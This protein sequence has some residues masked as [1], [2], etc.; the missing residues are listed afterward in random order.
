MSD[1]TLKTRFA[2]S[3]TGE[4]HLGNVRTALF[5]ALLARGG[6]GVF[7]L[8]IE[9]TDAERSREAYTDSLL[10]DLRWL[11]LDWDEG[12][13]FQRQRSD[14]YR[15]YYDELERRGASYPCFCSANELARTRRAQVAAGQPPRYAGTC[16]QLSA[17]E[18]RNRL[19]AG[20]RPAIRFRVPHG[21][22][23]AFHDLARGE[24]AFLSD[25]IGDFIIRRSDGSA[26]FLFTNA[27]DD[28]VMRVTHVLRGEDHLANTPRQ[29]M[30]L[31]A[32][33]LQPPAYGH[34][35]LLLAGDGVPLSKR[36]GSR[37]VR[38]LRERGYLPG[39]LLN[40]LARLGHS[41]D[42][43]AYADFEQLAAGFSLQRLGRAPAR[44]DGEQLR[45][46]QRQAL[47]AATVEQLVDWFKWSA[48]GAQLAPQVDDSALHAL[49]AMV[50]ENVT[51]PADLA[52][53]VRRLT[54]DSDEFDAD[55]RSVLRAAG[56]DFFQ[57][58]LDV[59]PATDSFRD[60]ANA[61]GR[62]TGRKGRALFLPLRVA[63]TG[64]PHGP[65]M[66]QIWVWLGPERCRERLRRALL[67]CSSGETPDA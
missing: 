30:L 22:R 20:A 47:N 58:A 61:T 67:C 55:S 60:F 18:V 56:S 26:A 54:G 12:P 14:V 35:A 64:A 10:T 44:Y 31:R 66:Q 27:I 40:Y 43:D 28:A 42:S 24:Q 3:P 7:L 25:D 49:V 11:G 36:H 29:V 13:Y 17:T 34:L 65:E 37:S 53:W 33:A 32:L 4:I 19:D 51:L 62:L 59:L 46:W 6:Q 9:D 5:N 2:P 1:S 41:F 16:A 21:A 50:R 45:Y 15:R 39:A 48:E 8:R 23:I 38:E 63:L 52:D 57:H